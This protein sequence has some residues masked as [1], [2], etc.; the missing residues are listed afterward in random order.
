[1]VPNFIDK[2]SLIL[3]GFEGGLIDP[4]TFDVFDDSKSII[5]VSSNN[6][7]V[8]IDWSIDVSDE[9][10]ESSKTSNVGGSMRPPSNPEVIKNK[11]SA[12][13]RLTIN[14]VNKSFRD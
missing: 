1:M 2:V 12:V 6:N 5:Q 4:P 7:I 10:F 11:N 8:S 14:Y 9:P 13:W 3:T